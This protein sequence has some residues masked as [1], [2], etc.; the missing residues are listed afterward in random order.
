MSFKKR[1]YHFRKVA[2]WLLSAILL[3]SFSFFSGLSDYTA[4]AS[5]ES[6]QTELVEQTKNFSGKTVKFEHK[7]LNAENATANNY[8]ASN[9]TLWCEF[10]NKSLLLRQKMTSKNYLE[11]RQSVSAYL[12]TIPK[13]QKESDIL[14]S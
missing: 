5:K 14:L 3:F 1:I 12:K 2:K 8:H 11:H 9:T 6:V 13:A 10:H 4:R 7:K